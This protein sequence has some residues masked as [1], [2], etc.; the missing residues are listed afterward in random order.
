VDAHRTVALAISPYTRRG[1][2]DS[3]FYNTTSVL[4]TIELLLGLDP[5]SP[6]DATATPMYKAFGSKADVTPYTAIKPA[7]DIDAKNPPKTALL[8]LQGKIDFSAPDRM[9]VAGEQRLNRVLWHSIKG[10]NTPYPGITRSP[11]FS[12]D[13]KAAVID[14]DESED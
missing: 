13:G 6:F 8:K 2:L 5:M 14:G 7:T 4:R 9:D 1:I 11:L 10:I 12:R 3:T